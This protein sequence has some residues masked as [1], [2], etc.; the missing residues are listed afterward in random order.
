MSGIIIIYSFSIFSTKSA[1]RLLFVLIAIEIFFAVVF[2]TYSLIGDPPP[3]IIHRWFNLNG[4]KNIPA[5][6]SSIQLFSVGI[7]L[8]V[9]ARQPRKLPLPSTI[10]LLILGAG[11]VFLSIDEAFSIHE[12]ITRMLKHI[13]WIPRF[14]GGHGI[15]IL[16]YLSLI[17]VFLSIFYKNFFAMWNQSKKETIL[18]SSGLGLFLLGAVGMEVIGYQFLTVA[19]TPTLYILE[20]TIE[21]FLEMFG[22]SLVLYGV[23]L[24]QINLTSNINK[25]VGKNS[26]Y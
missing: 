4:E 18:V 21:E 15:W 5:L 25:G 16:L 6:F 22:I 17:L 26:N 2:L 14:K 13:D 9:I 11:F 7:I 3:W 1:K 20:I 24:Y 8:F 23:I 19:N 10:F 12:S